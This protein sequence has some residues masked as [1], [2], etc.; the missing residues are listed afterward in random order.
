MGKTKPQI[1]PETF[2]CFG[3]YIEENNVV[4]QFTLGTSGQ[5]SDDLDF[6]SINSDFGWLF[7]YFLGC[8]HCHDLVSYQMIILAWFPKRKSFYA[9]FK[10]IFK[11]TAKDGKTT[12]VLR[13]MEWMTAMCSR[14]PNRSE[15]MV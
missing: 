15:Q 9:V 5:I 7:F 11:C 12:K 4:S 1:T 6:V 13:A 10:A 2:V 3:S 8:G 14:I